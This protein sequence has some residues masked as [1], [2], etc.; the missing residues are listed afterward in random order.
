LDSNSTLPVDSTLV[1]DFKIIIGKYT[2]KERAEKRVTNL[3]LNG[4]KVEMIQKDSTGFLV[5]TT[6]SCRVIDTA[7]VKDSLRIM[8]GYREVML[9][10]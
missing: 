3:T 9:Y 2:T 1:N 5:L 8:F 7:H 10:K 6:I 4:N